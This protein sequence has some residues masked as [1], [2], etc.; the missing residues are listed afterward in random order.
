MLSALPPAKPR[1]LEGV[2]L[3]LEVLAG[4]AQGLDLFGSGYPTQL[5]EQGMAAVFPADFPPD[6]DDAMA[7]EGETSKLNLYD[8]R[9]AEDQRALLD[10]CACPC[11]AEH[12]RA[13]L[14]HLLQTHELTA[15]V[16]LQL[17]NTWH[18][19]AFFAH[20]RRHVRAGTF[21][22]YHRRA[23]AFLARAS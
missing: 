12:T 3:P 5:T 7:D 18:Y 2:G 23:E 14:H 10:G 6:D 11:C 17:H 22:D 20:V 15:S 1:L 16:L 13:Y 19:A 4:V 9:Y 8:L 21:P